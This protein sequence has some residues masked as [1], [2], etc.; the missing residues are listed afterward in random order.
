M[1]TKKSYPYET[2]KKAV[3]MYHEGWRVEEV[4]EQLEIHQPRNIH[5]WVRLVK[6]ASSFKV[7]R[8]KR[9]GPSPG[10]PQRTELEIVKAELERKDLEVMYLKKLIA[11]RK[12]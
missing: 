8:E 1:E 6:E 12:G 7:L 11:L 4:A 9:R 3:E 10:G 5:R 2:K